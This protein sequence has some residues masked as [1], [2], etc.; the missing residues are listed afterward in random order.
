MKYKFLKAAF[1][2]LILSTSSLISVAN[3][4]LITLNGPGADDVDN[5]TAVSISLSSLDT[6]IINDLNINIHTTG[7]GYDL[8]VWLTHED[9][10][11]SAYIWRSTAGPVDFNG[12]HT[13]GEVDNL[14]DDEAALSFHPNFIG[15]FSVAYKSFDLLSVFDGEDISGTWSLNIINDGCC[16]SEGQDLI[17]WSIVAD[18]SAVPEPSTF[19]IFALGL[20]GLVSRQFKKKS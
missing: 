15:D 7:A 6:G 19:A 3:A 10:G 1:V 20:M 9:T 14:F 16:L 8:S 13:F 2:S 12:G 11:T 5:A 4:G 17:S 18:V